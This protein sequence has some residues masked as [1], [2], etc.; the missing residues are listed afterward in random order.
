MLAVGLTG[1]IG[2]GKSSVSSLLEGRGAVLV[3]ADRIARQVVERGGPAY[4]PLVDRFGTGIVG[5]DGAIDRAALAA[6]AFADPISL[7]DLNAITHPAVGA[8][9]AE[10]RDAEARSDHIVVFDVPLLRPEHRQSLELEL[11]VVVDCPP[12]VALERLLAARG[13]DRADAQARMAAQPTRQQRLADADWVVDNSGDRAHL[14]AE[15]QRLW[16]HLERLST[17]PQ[18]GG[19]TRAR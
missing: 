4:Q 14:V 3:D 9:M 19:A 17:G 11:V 15:V 5:P 13:M 1:G 12:E 18:A 2:A 10:R 16:A 6:L 7:A 8:V